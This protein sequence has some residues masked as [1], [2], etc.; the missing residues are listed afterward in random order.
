MSA[1]VWFR[2]AALLGLTAVAL[3]AFGAH[4]LRGRLQGALSGSSTEMPGT[5]S[6][7]RR[8]DVFETGVRYQMY[9]ALALFVVAW[10]SARDPNAALPQIAGWAFVVGV[11]LFSGSLYGIG[12]SGISALG[13]VTPMGG[14]AFLV[15]W[16]TLLMAAPGTAAGASSVTP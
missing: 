1:T 4:G 15:G 8:L 11:F 2:I 6:A 7:Q 12:L 3:G 9:H 14:L 13:A 16:T 10:L 5:V